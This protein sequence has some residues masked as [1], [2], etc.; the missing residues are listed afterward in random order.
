MPRRPLASLVA[1][2]A[3]ASL[4]GCQ[5]GALA[6]D[7]G[8]PI[9]TEGAEGA[10]GAQSQ[11]LP[12]MPQLCAELDGP[13]TA[14]AAEAAGFAPGAQEWQA[15]GDAWQREI[16]LPQP[17][18]TCAWTPVA[19]GDELVVVEVIEVDAA[20]LEAWE[21]SGAWSATMLGDHE[22]HADQRS[23]GATEV[24]T[25]WA[26]AGDRLLRITAVDAIATGTAMAESLVPAVLG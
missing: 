24:G 11:P 14:A 10:P 6:P 22:V 18:L 17:T 2:L 20:Q 23:D 21:A 25:T 12:P 15:T 7:G 26:A 3:I 1:A 4:T 16:D 9:T 5:A 19:A 13:G 8:A